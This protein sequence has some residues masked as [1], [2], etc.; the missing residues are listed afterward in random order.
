M[1]W[2]EFY[3]DLVDGLPMFPRIGP[4]AYYH[5]LRQKDDLQWDAQYAWVPHVETRPNHLNFLLTWQDSEDPRFLRALIKKA[6][7][8]APCG[9]L[10]VAYRKVPRQGK[11]LYSVA[12]FLNTNESW[13]WAVARQ[14]PQESYGVP[15]FLTVEPAQPDRLS[16]WDRLIGEPSDL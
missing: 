15:A 3:E 4:W 9:W 12:F 8:A 13:S 7:D 2:G 14:P 11:P 6:K 10:Y 5:V 1:I 16:M